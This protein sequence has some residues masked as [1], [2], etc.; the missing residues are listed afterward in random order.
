MKKILGVLLLLVPLLSG[1]YNYRELNDLGVVTAISIDYDKDKEVFKTKAQVINPVKQQNANSG[2]EPSFLVFDGEAKS[3]QESF[4]KAVEISPRQLY[5]SHLQILI[6]SEE[7]INNHLDSVL[8][9]LVRNPEL[10]SEFKV[11]IG[12][13]KESIDSLT[14]QTLLDSLSSSDLLDSLTL[15][16]SIEGISPVYTINDLSN[17]YLNPHL[18]IVLPSMTVEGNLKEGESEENKTSTKYKAHTKIST[19]AIFKDNKLLTYLNEK[20]SKSLNLI[21]G[22]LKETLIKIDT[23]EGY[24]VFEPNRIK[25]KTKVDVK[26]NKVK[27][28]I[29]GLSR[30]NEVTSNVNIKSPEEIDKLEKELNKY[31]E[32]SLL[33]TFTYIQ[34]EYNTDVFK[35]QD[36]YYKEDYKY[37]NKHYKDWYKNAFPNLKLEVEAN[38]SL[39]EK[40]NILGGFNY[41]R[42]NK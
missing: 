4:R 14:I 22:E 25:T 35:F 9:F 31:I 23:K 40:G 39:Y 42:K 24:I 12:K 17:A 28:T 33:D 26:N 29:K 16:N 27:L 11:I 34:K 38:I 21:R 15:Q 5:G 3:L 6:L 2:N 19:T 18:E 32:N 13:D 8:D 36:L 10:R 1:C 37:F 7:A 41:E 30:I 20:Q